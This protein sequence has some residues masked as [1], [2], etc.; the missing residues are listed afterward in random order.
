MPAPIR[1]DVHC[2]VLNARSVEVAEFLGARILPNTPAS[3]VPLVKKTLQRVENW[4]YASTHALPD[5]ATLDDVMP[6]EDDFRE[7]FTGIRGGLS[8]SRNEKKFHKLF[9]GLRDFFHVFFQRADRVFDCLADTYDSQGVD[10]YIPQIVDYDA[11][12]PGQS[13]LS[14]A[15]RI[16]VCHR[17]MKPASPHAGRLQPFVA[18][19]PVRAARIGIDET[20]GQL[21]RLIETK[22]FLGVKLYP[23][24]GFLPLGNITQTQ[25][26]PHARRKDGSEVTWRDVDQALRMLYR[27]CVAHN[28][29][30]TTHCSLGGAASPNTRDGMGHPANWEGVLRDRDDDF[31]QLRLNLAH[32]GG[33]DL[34]KNRNRWSQRIAQMIVRYPHVYTDLSCH[35]IPETG[36]RRRHYQKQLRQLL[37]DGGP[38]WQKIMYGSD[39]SMAPLFFPDYREAIT[40]FETLFQD[41]GQSVEQQEAF[42]GLNAVRF[43]GIG[44]ADAANPNSA[45]TR[46]AQFYQ[47]T[48][49]PLWWDRV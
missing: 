25:P 19:C 36:C 44:S 38:G 11:F 48:Q 15:R 3:L 26:V 33:D 9:D 12:L 49:L 2:H 34:H 28:V 22:G 10:L 40:R 16:A 29:P 24:M 5:L 4:A 21:T 7:T 39:W 46:L 20:I 17:W 41:M 27:Y 35:V 45:R 1:I 42:F 43:L 13:P 8:R 30:I 14:L 18:F 37:G 32:F 31:S 6:G 47:G 23:R